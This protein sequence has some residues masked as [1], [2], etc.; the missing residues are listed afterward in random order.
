MMNIVS[1]YLAMIIRQNDADFRDFASIAFERNRLKLGWKALEKGLAKYPDSRVLLD[2][3]LAQL[4]AQGKNADVAGFFAS[5]VA[6]KAVSADLFNWLFQALKRR[7]F[8]QRDA[9]WES[10]ISKL[11]SSS[12][13]L[14]Q[15]NRIEMPVYRALNMFSF[16]RLRQME[17]GPASAPFARDIDGG[18]C[19]PLDPAFD[20]LFDEGLSNV[21][22]YTP[23]NSAIMVGNSLAGG[24]ME[25]VLAR[26]YKHHAENDEIDSVK[27]ALLNYTVD[28]RTAFYSKEAGVSLEDINLLSRDG[29]FSP[30]MKPLPDGW[31]ARA[32]KLYDQILET[33]PRVIHAW[34]DLTGLLSA[35][36]GL[37]AGCPRIVVH[38]HHMPAVPIAGQAHQLASY[39]RLYRAL[40]MR[41]EFVPIF[42]SEASARAYADWWGVPFSDRFKVV[43]NGFDWP[44]PKG[45]VEVRTELGL[46]Q[47]AKI[48]G[49]VMRFDPVKQPL[50]WA[51]AAI[52]LAQLDEST[53]FVM[54]GEGPLQADVKEEFV[55][56]G[57][58]ARAHFPGQVS[59]VVD[60]YA[61][62][63]L[64]WLTSTSEGLPNVLVE[65][66]L[67]GVPVASFDV[68][69]AG[70]TF[71]P[72]ETGVLVA[73]DDIDALAQ[74][75]AALLS[76]EGRLDAM[77]AAA[78]VRAK[79]VFS[80]PGFYRKLSTVYG[81]E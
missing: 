41:E 10:A 66:Q 14:P 42:C 32:Q 19:S 45:K 29:P 1:A 50:L 40:L 6:R 23:E 35:Y 37:L 78:S 76:D 3:K 59:N 2:A 44:E 24:G 69:G 53:H 9:L 58:T 33:R 64:I 52:L 11:S 51:K 13:P 28:T 47:E 7:D 43:Y 16:A 73:A 8:D 68:G 75:S 71:V 65:A 46:P 27:L 38:F 4:V 12:M 63:D 81:A 54:V 77:S 31:R 17:M 48:V 74:Q 60:Y 49:A 21:E 36:A 20:Q 80:S 55:K 30:Q 70:E 61:A 22:P 67:L 39:P 18:D 79:A 72:D 15:R 62:M 25:R 34:N 5:L 56:A 57:L 26:T